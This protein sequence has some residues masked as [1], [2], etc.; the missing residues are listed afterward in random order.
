MTFAM[1]W[2]FLMTW[3]PYAIVSMWTAYG[4]PTKLPTRMT[5]MAVLTAKSST[6]VNP[7]IY[8]LMS[9]KFQPMLNQIVKSL[10]Q[11]SACNSA[12]VSLRSSPQ[13]SPSV[14]LRRSLDSHRNSDSSTSPKSDPSS[15]SSALT[16]IRI[17]GDSSSSTGS[18]N[19][20][21]V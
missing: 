6:V 8:V 3:M 16:T 17:K 13:C 9:K 5:V 15:P 7:V 2:G 18:S 1:C 4:D 11:H 19:E 14:S 20:S 12:S 21:Y 10:C